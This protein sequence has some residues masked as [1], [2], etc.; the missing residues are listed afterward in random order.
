M[1]K[2]RKIIYFWGSHVVF[3]FFIIFTFFVFSVSIISQKFKLVEAIFSLFFRLCFCCSVCAVFVILPL[4]RA[5]AQKRNIK[6]TTIHIFTVLTWRTNKNA[7]PVTWSCPNLF[8][9]F[10]ILCANY[11]LTWICFIW[12]EIYYMLYVSLETCCKFFFLQIV[13][14]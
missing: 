7:L 5:T 14:N 8:D 4:H 10:S 13:F 11:A 2:H 3:F 9:N 12:S 1:Q 6:H